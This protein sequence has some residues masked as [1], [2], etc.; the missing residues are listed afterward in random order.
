MST[1][2]H[3]GKISYVIIHLVHVRRFELELLLENIEDT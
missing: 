3:T 2:G 1:S